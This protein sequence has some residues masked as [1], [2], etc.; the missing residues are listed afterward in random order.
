MRR[1]FA[2][3]AVAVCALG[4]SATASAA[5]RIG[6]N[7]DWPKLDPSIYD[8][9]QRLGATVNVMT[10]SWDPLNPTA[11][12]SDFPNIRAAVA[13]AQRRGIE[14]ELATFQARSSGITSTP[15]GAELFSDW[16]VKVVSELA[17]QTGRITVLNE[18]NQPR[19]FQPIWNADC[20]AASPA[21]YRQVLERSYDKLKAFSAGVRV[22]GSLSPRGNNL[23]RA[24]SN[25]SLS[26]ARF[27]QELGAVYRAQDRSKQGAACRPLMDGLSFHPYPNE[28]TDDPFAAQQNP[29]HIGLTE[30][31]DLIRAFEDAF[32]G[33]CQPTFASAAGRF[34]LA[35]K[36]F[37]IQVDTAAVAGYDA[38]ENVPLA[39]PERQ[40]EIYAQAIRYVRCL[41]FVESFVFFH[42]ADGPNPN[43]AD[44][45]SGVMDINRTLRPSY[46]AVQSAVAEGEGCSNPPA[47]IPN[48]LQIARQRTVLGARADF[49]GVPRINSSRRR[50]YDVRF[51]AQE[52]A[53]LSVALY[54]L[55]G[56][57]LSARDRATIARSLQVVSSPAAVRPIARAKAYAKAYFN[58][59]VQVKRRLPKGTYVFAVRARAAAN[60]AR[61][62]L[63]VGRPFRVVTF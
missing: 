61:T 22:Y 34:F 29:N 5:V 14:V 6:F 28:N 8:H 24:A 33:T 58:V 45:N 1:L 17:L 4:F 19:F 37:G 51:T 39:S 38:A 56:K 21:V 9:Y 7:D 31:G 42:S 3:L 63:F 43:R 27:L 59:R 62:N 47:P 2:A 11:L 23:C 50:N 16:L 46:Q 55:G 49:R 26:P 25:A 48:P 60:P 30:L 18:P 10:V 20:S 15:D 13:E 57:R 54:R 52:D 41:P 36:E 32:G 44:F 35:L 53:N 40:A 12:P